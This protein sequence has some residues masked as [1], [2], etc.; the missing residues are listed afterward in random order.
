MDERE[1][2]VEPA[3]HAARVGA[4]L[5]VAGAREPDAL[6]QLSDQA[7]ALVAADAVERGLEAEVLD[8][9]QERVERSLLQRGPDRGADLGP[10][11]ATS[12]PATVAR[13]PDG[14]RRVVSM[15]TVVDLPAPFGPRKP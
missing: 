4:H 2:E 6:E 9:G 3:L 14:G 7:L 5:A 13:P 12:N 11:L 1:R 15:W 10:C 8:A